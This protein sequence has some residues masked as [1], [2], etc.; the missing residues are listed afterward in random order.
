[1]KHGLWFEGAPHDDKG[2]RI[3]WQGTSGVGRAVCRCGEMS[4]ILPS[5][6]AR[7]AWHRE[8]KRQVA[9]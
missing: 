6:N 7:K 3:G 4:P 2:H 9:K 8:H 5:G 1:M